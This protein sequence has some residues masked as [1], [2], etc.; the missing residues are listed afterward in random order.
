[1]F[2]VNNLH[3]KVFVFG[4]VAFVGSTNASN[5][6]AVQLL[7]A[8][9]ETREPGAVRQA[10]EFV[11]RHA[12]EPLGPEH[13]KRLIRMY[14]PPKFPGGRAA[15]KHRTGGG[16][17]F[18]PLR[19]VQLKPIGWTD[20]ETD[21]SE[22]GEPL[23]RKEL[24]PKFRLEQFSWSGST[25]KKGEH[26]VQV[27]ADERGKKKMVSPP[28]RVIHRQ[29][30][31]G[32]KRVIVFVEVPSRNRRALAAI[33]RRWGMSVAKRLSRGGVVTRNFGAQLRS[34]WAA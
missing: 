25:P 13:L 3:A 12:R 6:S 7:E 15:S 30:A 5:H 11:L 17:L 32:G 33:R 24:R 20:A 34:L 31:A 21:A 23:A 27:T 19:I 29:P 22:V 2:S 4:T 26:V 1:M 8:A 9:L 18:S 10:R 16:P 28:G 14:K